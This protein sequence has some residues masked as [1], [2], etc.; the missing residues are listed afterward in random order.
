MMSE[1]RPTLTIGAWKKPPLSLV[2]LRITECQDIFFSESNAGTDPVLKMD[3]EFELHGDHTIA[4]YLSRSQPKFTLYAEGDDDPVLGAAEIDQYLTVC[5]NYVDATSAAVKDLI[6]HLDSRLLARTFLV[7][8][9]LSLAD[10]A[11][12]ILL[13]D[14]SIDM[15][16]YSN[17]SRWKSHIESSTALLK[18]RQQVELKAAK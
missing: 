1:H 6:V 15:D 3:S 8:H 11:I 12:W 18:F 14:C 5:D 13:M 10:I 7:G 2:I 9:N 17:L 4:R 16:E